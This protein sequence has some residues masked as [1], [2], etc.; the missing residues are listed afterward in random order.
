MIYLCSV[1]LHVLHTR[2]LTN[3]LQIFSCE[4]LRFLLSL[5]RLFENSTS[6]L[7]ISVFDSNQ[8]LPPLKP[9]LPPTWR[10]IT[11]SVLVI[12]WNVWLPGILVCFVLPKMSEYEVQWYGV[13]LPWLTTLSRWGLIKEGEGVNSILIYRLVTTWR[14]S[15]LCILYFS[16]RLWC[17]HSFK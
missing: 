12:I 2:I 16:C 8:P 3:H 7:V 10:L 6:G 14:K 13:S 11:I 17:R 4:V 15:E 1:F 5:L 9:L